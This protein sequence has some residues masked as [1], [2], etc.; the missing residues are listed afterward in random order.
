MDDWIRYD[1]DYF[2]SE[3]AAVEGIHLGQWVGEYQS[4]Q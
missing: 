4:S 2:Q 3:L 1:Y